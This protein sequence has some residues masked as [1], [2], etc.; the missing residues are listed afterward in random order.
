MTCLT[1]ALDIDPM[2]LVSIDSSKIISLLYIEGAGG[3]FII[4][5]LGVSNNATLQSESLTKKQLQNQLS[6]ADKFQVIMSR[7]TA[8]NGNQWKDLGFQYDLFFGEDVVDP[9]HWNPT[10]IAA[11]QSGLYSFFEGHHWTHTEFYVKFFPEASI[12]HLVNTNEFISI[13]DRPNYP[14]VGKYWNQIRDVGWPEDPPLSAQDILKLPTF[15]QE[16][17]SSIF[18]N[19]IQEFFVDTDFEKCLLPSNKVYTWDCL[20]FLDDEQT[21]EGIRNLYKVFDL[22]DFNADWVAQYRRM[23][24]QKIQK[25]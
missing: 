8:E 6:P 18:Q 20:W 2:A 13:I 9:R 21:V 23:W 16:E 14:C 7:L 10:A 25:N 15:I 11:N 4:N 12:I 3:K 1:Q 5:C 22:S 24:I 17:L 19:Q